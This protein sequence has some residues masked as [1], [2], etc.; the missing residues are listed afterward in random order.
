VTVPYVRIN[1]PFRYNNLARKCPHDTFDLNYLFLGRIVG[2]LGKKEKVEECPKRNIEYRAEWR[3]ILEGPG[4]QG[5]VIT[6]TRWMGFGDAI[7]LPHVEGVPRKYFPDG[8]LKQAR[9]FG[10]YK[11]QF[12]KAQV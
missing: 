2:M 8:N 4:K 6:F 11:H 10:S 5:A 12:E 9:D 1:H 7:A 3:P